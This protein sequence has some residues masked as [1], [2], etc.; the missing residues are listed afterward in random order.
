M[1][2]VDDKWKDVEEER[3]LGADLLKVKI[4]RFKGCSAR[5]DKEWMGAWRVT[6]VGSPGSTF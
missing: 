3:Q 1:V 2:P 4:A 5:K 6:L